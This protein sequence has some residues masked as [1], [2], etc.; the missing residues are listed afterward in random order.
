VLGV[1]TP[2]HVVGLCSVLEA[3]Y[4]DASVR[5][6]DLMPDIPHLGIGTSLISHQDGMGRRQA[7]PRRTQHSALMIA[8]GVVAVP[9]SPEG[10]CGRGMADSRSVRH[11]QP[12]RVPTR[13]DAP[14][15]RCRHRP[16]HAQVSFRAPLVARGTTEPARWDLANAKAETST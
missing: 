11:P 10:A 8:G 4:I 14:C 16:G 5:D 9:P 2:A 1:S 6:R 3:L 15:P 7:A 12:F 13:H